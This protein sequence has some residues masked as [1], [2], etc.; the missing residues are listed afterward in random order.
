MRSWYGG[1]PIPYLARAGRTLSATISVAGWPQTSVEI[2][3][4]NEN[5]MVAVGGV[6]VM[7]GGFFTI[8]LIIVE[9]VVEHQ[10]L[11]ALLLRSFGLLLRSH[12]ERKCG[13]RRQLNRACLEKLSVYIISK[14]T[15]VNVL[16]C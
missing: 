9:I 16:T 12:G 3:F 10:V 1:I 13:I 14:R 11:D 7:K 4:A 15:P 5:G 6:N 2:A 8:M